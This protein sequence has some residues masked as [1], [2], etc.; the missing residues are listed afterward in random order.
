MI[1]SGAQKMRGESWGGR[2]EEIGW[3]TAFL[4]SLQAAVISSGLLPKAS[5]EIRL[6]RKPRVVTRDRERDRTA[7]LSQRATGVDRSCGG[8]IA[9]STGVAL[10]VRFESVRLAD[11]LL[12][13]R[14]VF[15]EVVPEPR[16]VGE[17][18][19][20]ERLSEP[21]GAFSHG[22]EV[23]EQRMLAPVLSEVRQRA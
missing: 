3:S 10:D 14:G 1:L 16:E 13:R 22:P 19:P 18:A 20:P 12:E 23:V 7:G 5:T 15:A 11:H 21:R 4:G 17:I 2:R 8:V 9:W 6:V